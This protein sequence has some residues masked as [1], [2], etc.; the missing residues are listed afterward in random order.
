MLQISSQA[1]KW[2]HHFPEDKRTIMRAYTGLSQSCRGEQS[3]ILQV[4]FSTPLMGFNG[5]ILWPVGHDEI[6]LVI[7]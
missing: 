2:T 5:G 6:P 1:L 4:L 7:A 3:N